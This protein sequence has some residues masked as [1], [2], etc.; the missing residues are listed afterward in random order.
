MRANDEVPKLTQTR[1][2]RLFAEV[3]DDKKADGAAIASS[4]I[5]GRAIEI[6]V[7]AKNASELRAAVQAVMIAFARRL[8]TL[9]G[10]SG[11]VWADRYHVVSR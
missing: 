11:K 2:A 9:L 5:D 4:K 1:I 3:V 10:R 6:V 7:R 8:N